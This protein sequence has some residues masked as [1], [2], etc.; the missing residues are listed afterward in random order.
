M[1]NNTDRI[2]MNFSEANIRWVSLAPSEVALDLANPDVK[3]LL[4]G[5]ANLLV[6]DVVRDLTPA[7]SDKQEQ[8]AT[9]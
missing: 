9:K 7:E 3:L 8:S 1:A 5:L 6:V 4:S 2:P